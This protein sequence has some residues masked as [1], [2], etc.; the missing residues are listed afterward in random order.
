V[1]KA[2]VEKGRAFEDTVELWLSHKGYAY[3]RG[4]KVRTV[5]GFTAEVDFVVYDKRGKFIV[6]AKNLEK[7]VDRD[8]VLKAWN[9]AVAL[10]AY[11]AVVVS[12]SGFTEAAISLARRIGVVELLTLEDVLAE[13]EEISKPTTLYVEPSITAWSAMRWAEDILAERRLLIFKAERSESVESIYIPVYHMKASV[14][15]DE[16]RYRDVIVLSSG[17]TGLPIAYYEDNPRRLREALDLLV[18]LPR[19]VVEVYR[20]YAGRRVERREIVYRYGESLWVK[21]VRHLTPRGL[22][23]RVSEKPV[24]VELVNIYPSLEQLEKAAATI[25]GRRMLRNPPEG[26]EVREP[27]YSPGSAKLFLETV[28]KAEVRAVNQL[29]LPVHR[30]KLVDSRGSYRYV[31]IAAWARELLVYESKY[32]A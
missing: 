22:V 4:V 5:Y 28:L 17:L 16:G 21:M 10:G 14:S 12:A 9:N 1:G 24:I 19:D 11:K 18:D 13:L 29:Y 7:P 23:R 32:L 20:L 6:E 27:V 3:E 8:V 25:E 30:V 26:F 15:V 2:S 31:A